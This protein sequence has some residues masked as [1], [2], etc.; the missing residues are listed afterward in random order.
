MN[1]SFNT[2][3]EEL[4]YRKAA[5]RILE[6]IESRGFT[7]EEP[8]RAV[9]LTDKIIDIILE[10]VRGNTSYC[11]SEEASVADVLLALKAEDGDL[12]NQ[13]PPDDYPP[14]HPLES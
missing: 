3:D 7:T 11:V 14:W 5:S 10:T 8:L 13:G 2:S 4:L 12:E 6:E 1:T 9:G